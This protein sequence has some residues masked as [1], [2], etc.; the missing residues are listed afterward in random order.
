MIQRTILINAVAA[1]LLPLS[2]SA[3]A[4]ERPH[5]EARSVLRQAVAA[6]IAGSAIGLIARGDQILLVEAAGEIG[7]GEPMPVNAIARV[8]SIQKPITA[9]AVL[10]LHERGQL[11]L[12]DPVE[13]WNGGTGTRFEVDPA[14]GMIAIVFI[15]TWP[16]TP[17]VSDVRNEFIAKALAAGP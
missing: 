2:V 7:P 6:G 8:A 12:A 5:E 16:G 11:D 13:T 4:P 9:A 14:T 3:Q 17:G 15:P 10:I 1:I